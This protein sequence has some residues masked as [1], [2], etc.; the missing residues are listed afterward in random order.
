MNCVSQQFRVEILILIVMVFR[1]RIFGEVRGHEVESSY[2]GLVPLLK[3]P[4][5]DT[6]PFC[7]VMP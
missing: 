5:R 7:L 1:A 4:E 3:S 2:I 6:L